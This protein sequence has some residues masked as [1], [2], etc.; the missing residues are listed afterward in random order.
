MPR[1]RYRKYNRKRKRY[2]KRNRMNTYSLKGPVQQPDRVM[3][4]LK[5]TEIVNYSGSPLI[6]QIF[7]ANGI[8]DPNL[9]SSGLQPNGFDQWAALYD[10]Y[11]VHAC[12]INTSIIATGTGNASNTC[13]VSVTPSNLPTAVGSSLEGII[14]NPYCKYK[15]V[16][17]NLGTSIAYISN[18]VNIKN[19]MG[20]KGVPYDDVN[21][22]ETNADPSRQVYWVI[23]AGTIDKLTNI[24]IKMMHVMT[25]YVEFFDR[26]QLS[27]S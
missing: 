6:E 21:Q 11:R 2:N 19:F 9:T 14:G 4:K 22:A 15:V 25:Y 16:G 5:Y 13:I 18:Y 24:D 8:F 10:R 12:K 27:R 23:E 1:K 26:R 17:P 7:R 20:K 3:I